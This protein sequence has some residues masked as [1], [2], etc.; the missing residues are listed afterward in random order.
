MDTNRHTRRMLCEDEGRDKGDAA[1]ARKHQ[2]LPANH[3]KL[4]WSGENI[5]HYSQR[6]EPC[7][8]LGPGLSDSR[9]LTQQI[10]A[11]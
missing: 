8:H 3:Q 5:L 10:Y 9:T 4:E 7:Q 2:R 1:E 11:V 6:N